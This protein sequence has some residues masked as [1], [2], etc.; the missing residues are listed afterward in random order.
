MRTSRSKIRH[1]T[2]KKYENITLYHFRLSSWKTP[3]VKE[4][5][6][7][8]VHTKNRVSD[9]YLF[10]FCISLLILLAVVLAVFFIRLK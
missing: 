7:K 6:V 10:V 8:K 2:Y 4:T 1:L 5:L 9:V 3:E